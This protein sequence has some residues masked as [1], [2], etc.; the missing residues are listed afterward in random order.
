MSGNIR[1]TQILLKRGNTA[2]ASSY[3]GPI[4][5][6][7][8]DT[9]LQTLRIQDGLTPGG[10]I[11]SA[12]LT[13]INSNIASLQSSISAITGIDTEFVANINALLSNA[14]TQQTQINTL[15]GDFIFEGNI[16]RDPNAFSLS[17]QIDNG[18]STARLSIPAYGDASNPITLYNNYGNVDVLVG[19]DSTITGAWQFNNNGQLNVPQFSGLNIN[20]YSDTAGA[21]DSHLDQLQLY[22]T[23]LDGLRIKN[24]VDG[25]DH[26]WKFGKDK[27]VYLPSDGGIVFS[28]GT[29]TMPYLGPTGDMVSVMSTPPMAATGALWYS[30]EDGRLYIS[31]GD[32]WVDAS[33]Q[34]VPTNMVGYDVNGNITLP[35]NLDFTSSPAI[36]TTGIV[37]GDGTFQTT[38]YTGGGSVGTPT[39]VI[40]TAGTYNNPHIV[41][42]NPTDN[43]WNFGFYSDNASQFF[44]QT[45]FYGDGT[46]NRGFRVLDL[47]NGNT[48]LTVDS[49]NIV[50]LGSGA[51][52]AFADGGMIDSVGSGVLGIQY[53]QS[54]GIQVAQIN[55]LGTSSL[56]LQANNNNFVFGSDGTL[57]LAGPVLGVARPQFPPAPPG[58]ILDY[59]VLVQPNS[60]DSS[61]QF[62]FWLSPGTTQG[63]F[64]LP[65]SG[66]T[67]VMGI[68]LSHTNGNTGELFTDESG[69]NLYALGGN[70]NLYT[71][72]GTNSYTLT[73]NSTDGSLIFPDHTI[74][75]TA[76]TGPQDLSGY[77]TTSAV[78]TA[79]STAINNL[80]DS[81]PGTLDTLQEIAANL[82]A[83]AGAIGSIT[84]SIASTNA[85]VTAANLTIAGLLTNH[86]T[87][88][89][90]FTLFDGIGSTI[91]ATGAVDNSYA[92]AGVYYLQ[93][94]KTKLPSNFNTQ[95]SAGTWT[96][97]CNTDTS[98]VTSVE[99]VDYYGTPAWK[100]HTSSSVSGAGYIPTF[101]QHTSN[102]S[103][104]FPDS[105][106]QT[107]AYT[108]FGNANVA[109]YLAQSSSSPIT[110]TGNIGGG[111]VIV[112]NNITASTFT[113][114]NGAPYA[115][116]YSNAN[117]ISYLSTNTATVANLVIT[118]S[119]P[120]SLIGTAGDVAGM[121]RVDSNYI[122][123][124]TTTFTPSTYTV[125]W[126]GATSGTIFLTKGSYPQPQTGWT[127]S[128]ISGYG[129]T[130]TI[131]G[132]SDGGS[133]WQ[134]T[135]TP[136]LG[137]ASGGTVTLTNP[138]P[139]TIWTKTPI[140]A[141]TY[142]NANVAAYLVSNPQAGTYSNSN[143]ASYLVANP[144]AG[145]Y[146]N[147]NVTAL[148]SGNVSSGNLA[149]GHLQLHGLDYSIGTDNGAAVTFN[150]RVNINGSSVNIGLYV[151][152]N[153]S[154][155]QNSNASSFYGGGF[156]WSGNG[157]SILS[158]I[159][160]TYSNANVA[161]YLP[162]YSGNIGAGN[163]ITTGTTINTGV[164]S[165]GNIVTTANFVGSGQYLTNLSYTATGN[166]V[167]TSPNVT[168][169]AGSYS[170]IFDNT[171]N[172]TLANVANA[173]I[174]G[175]SING[176][177]ILNPAG[178]GDVY[179]TPNTQLY[180]QD[181]TA[182][183]SITTGAVVV[184]GGVGIGGNLNVG[185]V[186]LVQKHSILSGIQSAPTAGAIT[187]NAMVSFGGA[188]GNQLAMGQYPIGSTYGGTN[189]QY[190]QWLQSGYVGNAT[191][192]PIVL[193][194]LGGG[195]VVTGGGMISKAFTANLALNTNLTLDNVNLQ[196]QSQNS[197][198]WLFAGTVSGTSTYSYNLLW[199]F[200][201]GSGSS[202]LS[203]MG[204]M[205]ATT[206]VASIG[207][208][209]F[210]ALTANDLVT[211]N[212]VDMTNSK[213]YR[214]TMQLTS[215]SSPY[216]TF[217]TIERV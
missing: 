36:Q 19:T 136:T 33:P 107:T 35:S 116:T 114:P 74:Q 200:N 199:Q 133:S 96:V 158:G 131:T 37:F 94:I 18:S 104:T 106:V 189:V 56:T 152:S 159:G 100:I 203:S 21:G 178:T 87:G 108:G 206:T 11:A 161:S 28:G 182:S 212:L 77:A 170:T 46:A 165:T 61:R 102:G 63:G 95:L 216:G 146:S 39:Q 48:P 15:T 129:G 149:I 153:V 109:A 82:A 197:G 190:S 40:G 3:I 125:G 121:I 27:N 34:V 53:L 145:T 16:L 30:T 193:N 140:A 90:G 169:I 194:P 65:P 10:H 62:V 32:F 123:Y 151:S 99:S 13:G 23:H 69:T 138:N 25:V 8:I 92:L 204:S 173:Y 98:T 150:N 112:I 166:I 6:I 187:A 52:L 157:V 118:G 188:G 14:A 78:D 181:P 213:M 93:I 143:V 22:N 72:N 115:G 70:I 120:S 117:V 130:L 4:G 41:Q 207:S 105:T 134:C 202:P 5:E 12:D 75:T 214:I 119:A 176:N 31:N 205:S 215:G 195:V 171:G 137:S 164:T 126:G 49:R 180:I 191:Y 142:A 211:C 196:I 45:T 208:T 58:S 2:A 113:Y 51:Q 148:L 24:T 17:N 54:T 141:T 73:L 132:V 86:I 209:S 154:V 79:I 1:L 192:Y 83:E 160:G 97:Q 64:E 57:A 201:T 175:S 44:T 155:G 177:I 76:F 184:A 85:N 67:G 47:Q 50:T 91:V 101:V 168:L 66:D 198:I 80:I 26:E 89:S 147:T 217:V 68:N 122:Y 210:S 43:N 71:N 20:W 185:N 167:G 7:V 55:G 59:R 110:T 103:I 29:Q 88:V 139:P 111:N 174:N 162:V 124:C 60:G 144:Q 183:T 127:V 42:V 156:Y 128:G 172:V 9:D 38:A 135:A 186:N 84:S 163:V 81:A 179:I